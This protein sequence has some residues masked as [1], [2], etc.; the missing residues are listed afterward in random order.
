MIGHGESQGIHARRQLV[1]GQAA[2][3]VLWT[4]RRAVPGTFGA[5]LWE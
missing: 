4:G 1:A 2:Q 3:R 5:G